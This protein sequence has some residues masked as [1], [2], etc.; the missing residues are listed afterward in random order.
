MKEALGNAIGNDRMAAKGQEEKST[1]DTR[2]A[3]DRA[4]DAFK[5]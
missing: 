5:P 1:G 2:K 3:K 4:K